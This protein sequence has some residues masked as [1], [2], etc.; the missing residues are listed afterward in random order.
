MRTK[1]SQKN[2]AILIPFYR[3][4]LTEYEQISLS[5]CIKVLKKYDI[6][7]FCPEGL[8]IQNIKKKY[9]IS[10]IEWFEREN[11]ISTETYSRLLLT[12]EFYQRFIN[13]KF[14][15]IYQL[16]AFVFE[17]RL[18]DWCDTNQDYIGAPWIGESWPDSVMPGAKKPLWANNSLFQSLFFKKE[19]LVGNGGFSLRKVSRSISAL[20]LL[21]RY[22]S[23]WPTNEDIFWSIFVPNLLPFFK[24]PDMKTAAS[25]SLELQ[26]RKGFVLNGEVLPFGC[27]AW[28]K[29]DLEFWRPHFKNQGYSI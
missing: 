27:H 14:I 20:K 4:S 28:E 15:L 1:K 13:Y 18:L 8:T 23:T 3:N 24:V 9:G 11:F 22:A 19:N 17:D 12:R 25:F 26:P 7:F 5:Q 21:G 10:H 6:I 29:W 16:D 2:V